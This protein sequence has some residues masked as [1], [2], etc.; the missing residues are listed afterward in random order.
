MKKIECRRCGTCCVKGGPVL[1]SDD[2]PLIRNKT[3]R[4]DQLVVIRKGE[5]AYNPATDAVEPASCEMLKLQGKS[6]SWECLFYDASQKSCTIHDNRPLECQLLQ[7][8]D[9]SAILAVTGKDCLSRQDIIPPDDPA[10]AYLQ[11]FEQ[12]SWEKVHLLLATLNTQSIQETEKILCTD[13]LL[14]QQAVD[15][16]QITLA[17]ELFYFGRPMFQAFSHPGV[18]L[19]FEKGMPRLHLL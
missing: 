4:L 18:Q 6:G 19:T 2:L 5:P 1:H 15:R 7:C 17:Q 11:A 9:T 3:I 13:L 16:L 8:R 10:L 12:C 14:R